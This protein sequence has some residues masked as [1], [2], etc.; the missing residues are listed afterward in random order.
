MDDSGGAYISLA[1]GEVRDSVSLDELED[2]GRIAALESLEQALLL[3]ATDVARAVALAQLAALLGAAALTAV[4]LIGR[5]RWRHRRYAIAPY[6]TDDATPEQ[7][8][9]LFQDA[10]FAVIDLG[11]LA[12]GGAMQQIHHPLAGVNLIRL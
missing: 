8:L 2:A 1:E 7:V 6:R 9:A 10:G 5:R 3:T 4:R 11:D 12:A